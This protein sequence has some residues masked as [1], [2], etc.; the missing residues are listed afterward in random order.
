MSISNLP[1]A[2]QGAD[3]K[4]RLFRIER[5]PRTGR[6]FYHTIVGGQK[7]VVVKVGVDGW[8]AWFVDEP[9]RTVFV[10]G[11]TA[12]DARAQL[13][14]LLYESVM[15]RA[16]VI[17]PE[18]CLAL[19]PWAN[20]PK[21]VRISERAL[22]KLHRKAAVNKVVRKVHKNDGIATH[23]DLDTLESIKKPLPA[24]DAIDVKSE[25]KKLQSALVDAITACPYWG[26]PAQRRFRLTARQY[27][28]KEGEEGN[29]MLSNGRKGPKIVVG[30]IPRPSKRGWLDRSKVLDLPL[31]QFVKQVYP[32]LP[33]V[34]EAEND[35]MPPF[36]Q[37]RPTI[38]DK[39][40]L[41]SEIEHALDNGTD[42]AVSISG[43]KDSDAMAVLLVRMHK[44]RGWTGEIELVHA[45]LGRGEWS[46][47]PAHVEKLAEHLGLPLSIVSRPQGDFVA[48]IWQRHESRPDAPPFP[49]AAARY[50]TAEL[51]TGQVDKWLREFTPEGV[52]VCALGIRAQESPAR[53]K[54]SPVQERG[55]I[56]TRKRTGWTWLPLFDFSEEDVWE[57][58][59]TSRAE[60][61][62][63]RA[64][65]RQAQQDGLDPLDAMAT[66][67][68]H[69]AY[70]FGN[71]RLSCAICVLA[72]ENDIRNGIDDNP[73]LYRELC[74]IEGASG[75]T[76]RQNM[77]LSDLR[78]DLLER[79]E[80]VVTEEVPF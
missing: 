9:D 51:K 57:A 69:P 80:P 30:H 3:K 50:C 1:Q 36:E 2:R 79:I 60:L 73:E 38:L 5:H 65:V 39:V 12:R 33:D 8:K 37:R 32:D 16:L 72:T 17:R 18:P 76:F 59:G 40:V 49:S 67:P 29:V 66:W 21:R 62:A 54:K 31:E 61:E 19:V 27:R 63:I 6:I 28:L 35:E 77:R 23:E 25:V 45:D 71:E 68:A 13:S 44:E 74:R 22:T 48:R 64:D 41:P 26:E 15:T 10:K 43:G 7:A 52:V 34:V 55:K 11:G 78:P 20:R 14:G 75:F 47:T 42:L 4:A 46:Y 56:T 70:A 53:A 24:P 58:L